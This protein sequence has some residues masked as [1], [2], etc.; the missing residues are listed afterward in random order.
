MQAKTCS[1][2]GSVV[3]HWQAA[4]KASPREEPLVGSAENE[5]LREVPKQVDDANVL[6][7]YMVKLRTA[8]KLH[9]KHSI[10]KA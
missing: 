2:F 9:K 8:H 5:A 1:A 10:G 6:T 7:K 3:A 4:W